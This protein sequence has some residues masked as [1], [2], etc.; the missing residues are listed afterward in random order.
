MS[1]ADDN[2]DRNAI[3]FDELDRAVASVLNAP[4]ETDDGSD[5]SVSVR[6][7]DHHKSEAVEVKPTESTAPL[8][9]PVPDDGEADPKI[10]EDSKKP[11][12][13]S[14]QEL[15]PTVTKPVQRGRFLDM[16]HPAH[17]M[18]PRGPGGPV[19]RPGAR[20]APVDSPVAADQTFVSDVVSPQPPTVSVPAASE[21]AP[22]SSSPSAVPK[23][24]TPAVQQ[25]PVDFFAAT[26]EDDTAKPD[27]PSL[28]PFIP[29]AKVEKRPLGA[30]SPADK[31]SAD[32]SLPVG[33]ALTERLVEVESEDNVVDANEPTISRTFTPFTTKP[34][35]KSPTTSLA[36][37]SATK[38]SKAKRSN[39]T[40]IWLTVFVAVAL[41]GF[42]VGATLYF[43]VL[44]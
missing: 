16:V 26:G 11:S 4:D 31:P 23:P 42:G 25:E 19:T 38:T 33:E 30:F 36:I 27:E 37:G 35:A 18:A 32:T 44:K 5:S 22:H 9:E 20:M 21:T 40:F 39:G 1:K 29:D 12:P 43:F 24:Q 34:S 17:D 15:H 8:E 2:T 10:E 13:V 28:S 7:G 14:A 3:D 41:I 6:S